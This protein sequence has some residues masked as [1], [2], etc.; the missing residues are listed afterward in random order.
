[1]STETYVKGRCRSCGTSVRYPMNGHTVEALQAELS[2]SEGYECPGRHVEL[3]S[4]FDGYVWDFT[5][6]TE[7]EPASDEEYGKALVVRYGRERV[8]HLGQDKLGASLG[9]RSLHELK[10]L[11]HLGSG[12]FIHPA[13]SRLYQRF[14][15]PRGARFY[16][17]QD[18]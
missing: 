15:S 12:E 5:P 2:S 1:M 10:G 11:E 17:Q 16:V 8:F 6:V 4:L 9:I 13:E 7:P 18:V 3:G 14:D